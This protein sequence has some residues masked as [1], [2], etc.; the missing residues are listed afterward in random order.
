MTVRAMSYPSSSSSAQAARQRLA[1][2]LRQ[3][4]QDAGISGV[5]F[6]RRAGWRYSTT[7]TKI[8]RA[9]RPAS[10]EHVRLWC[11]IC[12]ASS[13]REAE[14]LAEQ[15]DVARM[16]ITYEQLN[17]GGLKAA[18]KSVRE[19]YE[20][21]TL[22]R[23]YQSKVIHGMLQTEAYTRAALA[24]AQ[25]EQ[26]VDVGDLDADLVEAVAER[27]DR[28][29]L[30]R[31]PDARWLFLIEEWVLWLCPYARSLHIE[32]LRYL[33][34]A[35]KRPN[36]LIGIIPADTNRNGIHPTEA[37]DITDSELVTVE[38]VSG[39]LSVTQP[40]EIAMYLEKWRQ[41]WSLAAIGNRAA[42]TIKRAIG[43]LRDQEGV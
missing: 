18:Q 35:M 17:R 19:E 31:R 15:R 9:Q 23:A 10:P 29:T 11:R 37:F 42:G 40:V 26:G 24:T 14:L 5:E 33:L 28:Q 34:A 8:E 4:R 20:Q 16:W 27:M 32:Q 25:A 6:A 12:G 21:L 2:Q 38:L 3:M 22:S 30:L 43:T 13:R 1:D 41:L 36:V 7:V 39:Y